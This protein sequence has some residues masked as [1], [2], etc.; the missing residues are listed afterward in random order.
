[1]WVGT[2][3]AN[4]IIQNQ[5]E[6]K[7][8]ATSPET[9]IQLYAEVS[10]KIEEEIDQMFIENGLQ[11]AKLDPNYI[12]TNLDYT[13]LDQ[14]SEYNKIEPKISKL[15]GTSDFFTLE[16]AKKIISVGKEFT[17]GGKDGVPLFAS[18]TMKGAT[19]SMLQLVEIMKRSNLT[20]VQEW[21]ET[22][23]MKTL[24][25]TTLATNIKYYNK[26]RTEAEH[27]KNQTRLLYE[28]TIR[29]KLPTAT[30]TL[31]KGPE[32]STGIAFPP[33]FTP[34]QAAQQQV[35]TFSITLGYQEWL[36]TIMYS[37]FLLSVIVRIAV[38]AGK[39]IKGKLTRGR[40]SQSPQRRFGAGGSDRPDDFPP[41]GPPR[42]SPRTSPSKVEPLEEET[43][44]EVV[45]KKQKSPKGKIP[46]ESEIQLIDFNTPLIDVDIIPEETFY[47]KIK[48]KIKGKTKPKSISPKSI[49]LEKTL[50]GAFAG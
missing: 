43:Y 4:V 14:I 10:Q 20:L 28:G 36:I 49:S 48:G 19:K 9:Q 33:N 35:N 22:A 47:E 34:S 5:Q 13:K 25:T 8:I 38:A 26:L 45:E 29:Y 3:E 30:L 23:A 39:F 15:F 41:R 17:L 42:G 1:M 2:G 7:M 24:P 44:I 31:G 11:I 40:R 37:L 18:Y 27:L 32:P 46:K 16:N 12:P 50:S 21:T 6:V